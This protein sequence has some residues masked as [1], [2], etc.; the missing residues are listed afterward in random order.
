[1][2]N[3][4]ITAATVQSCISSIFSKDDVLNLLEQQK[5]E[6]LASIPEPE[7][8]VLTV[9]YFAPISREVLEKVAAAVLASFED[10]LKDG[11]RNV[12]FQDILNECDVEVSYDKRIELSIDDRSAADAVDE[13]IRYELPDSEALA[14]LIAQELKDAQDQSDTEP[15]EPQA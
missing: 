4:S 2:E 10:S 1:M 6:I 7:P 3:Q 15:T 11:L 13:A 14:D 9:P 5:A 8:Q 12:D